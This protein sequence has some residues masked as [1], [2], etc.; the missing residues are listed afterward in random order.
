MAYLSH[1]AVFYPRAINLAYKAL[2]LQTFTQNRS[3]TPN[4]S[5][6]VYYWRQRQRRQARARTKHIL[7]EGKHRVF[8]FLKVLWTTKESPS[9]WKYEVEFTMQE[10]FHTDSFYLGSGLLLTYI[11]FLITQSSV[12][13]LS[14]DSA[15]HTNEWIRILSINNQPVEVRRSLLQWLTWLTLCVAASSLCT[16]FLC[17]GI[18]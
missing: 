9:G 17:W 6:E 4:W 12:I 16:Y 13:N 1:P 18:N 14:L 15:C 10:G 5:S 11:Y 2:T 7:D 8:F 3:R